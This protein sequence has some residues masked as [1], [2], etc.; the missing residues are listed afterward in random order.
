MDE[1]KEDLF[2]VEVKK[3]EVAYKD[4]TK[5]ISDILNKPG[6]HVGLITNEVDSIGGNHYHKKSTQ[7]S[8]ILSGKHEVLLAQAEDP[9]NVKKVVV[10]TGDLIII[11]PNIIHQFKTIEKA[12]M[13]DIVSESR[14]GTGYEDDVYRIKIE[15]A[16]K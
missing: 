6:G 16:K 14:E 1:K 11:P 2:G 7:Y 10:R 13:V 5:S 12:I 4:E 8:Y 3:I 9:S 15:E